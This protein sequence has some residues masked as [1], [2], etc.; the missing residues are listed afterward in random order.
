MERL[1]K[2][3]GISEEELNR[4]PLKHFDK[5]TPDYPVIWDDEDSPRPTAG[6]ITWNGW[7][8]LDN[9]RNYRIVRYGSGKY[10]DPSRKKYICPECDE[11]LVDSIAL[12]YHRATG[13]CK[14][15][16]PEQLRTLRSTRKLE[17]AR[18]A[19]AANCYEIVDILASNGKRIRSVGIFKYLGTTVAWDCTSSNEVNRRLGL[20][21]A[22]FKELKG[23]WEDKFLSRKT[24]LELYESLVMSILLYNSEDWLLGKNERRRLNGFHRHCV[25][26]IFQGRHNLRWRKKKRVQGNEYDKHLKKTFERV[27]SIDGLILMRTIKFVGHI[28]RNHDISTIDSFLSERDDQG[29]WWDQY[30]KQLAVYGLKHEYILKY[31]ATP[32]L[33]NEFLSRVNGR[34]LRTVP[35]ESDSESTS[36]QNS[37]SGSR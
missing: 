7:I 10:V 2:K 25:E 23:I 29:H 34:M 30:K 5:E 37:S 32:G 3:A 4:I 22:V 16:T 35:S 20:A 8:K 33:W 17:E 18:R 6:K 28:F 11:H 14:S 13:Y 9:G 26:R 12:K 31:C 21:E 24:K 27:K 15:R 36:D 19:K 1:K